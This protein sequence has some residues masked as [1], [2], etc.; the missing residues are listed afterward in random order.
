MYA[1][2][3]DD[4]G[5]AGY[6]PGYRDAVE[7]QLNRFLSDGVENLNVKRVLRCG[8]P[9]HEIAKY[10]DSEKTGLIVMPTH[11]YGP[12]RRFLLGSVTAKVLHDADCPVWTGVHLEDCAARPAASF[13]RIL[14]A[15]DPWD[16]DHKALA[17][18]WEFGRETG[19]QVKIVYAVPPIYG[20]DSPHFDED[21]KKH[22]IQQAEEEIFKAQSAVGSVADIEIRPGEAAPA[23]CAAA[24][25]WDANLL[26]I[27]RGVASGFMGRLRSR[28]Y[29]IIRESP[30]PVVSV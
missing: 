20:P 11:G 17:W 16:S 7:D 6:G 10:A 9:A 21:M 3:S 23:V 30:C 5:L 18:A 26:V 4:A 12:F 25:E 13:G 1:M 27:G 8:D 2:G 22:R 14:C 19:G 24:G 29:S 15:V 28:S